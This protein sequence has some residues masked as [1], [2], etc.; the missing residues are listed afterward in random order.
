[1]VVVRW[2][3]DV[4]IFAMTIVYGYSI[5]V[6]LKR[7]APYLRSYSIRLQLARRAS[8]GKMTPEVADYDRR[9]YFLQIVMVLVPVIEFIV[10]CAFWHFLPKDE[11]CFNACLIIAV[12]FMAASGLVAMLPFIFFRIFRSSSS[13]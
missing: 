5:W 6:F 1:M 13:P 4:V 2:V 9:L 3:F 11:V 12:V 10:L 8:E 7:C